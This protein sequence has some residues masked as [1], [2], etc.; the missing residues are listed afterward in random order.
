[1]DEATMNRPYYDVRTDNNS[2]KNEG[3]KFEIISNR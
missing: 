1:M 3:S 2:I